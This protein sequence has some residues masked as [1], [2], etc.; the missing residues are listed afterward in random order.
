MSDFEV[1]LMFPDDSSDFIAEIVYG[2]EWV[3]NV[4]QEEGPLDFNIELGNCAKTFPLNGFYAALEYAQ[5]RLRDL[6]AKVND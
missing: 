6:S 1:N 4:T 2:S 3:C 5:M